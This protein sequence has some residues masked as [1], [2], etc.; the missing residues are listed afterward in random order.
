M[1]TV[2][3]VLKRIEIFLESRHMHRNEK[4][5]TASEFKEIGKAIKRLD[6]IFATWRLSLAHLLVGEG[7]SIKIF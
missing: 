7:K 5:A 6:S 3:G 2:L 4:Q 1:K